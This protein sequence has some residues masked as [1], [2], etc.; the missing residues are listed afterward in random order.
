MAPMSVMERPLN[1]ENRIAAITASVPL[2]ERIGHRPQPPLLDQGRSE[3]I[4]FPIGQQAFQQ[5]LQT[6]AA[7][8]E[9]HEE[10]LV[11]GDN[12]AKL[13]PPSLSAAGAGLGSQGRCGLAA[14]VLPETRFLAKAGLGSR[15]PPHHPACLEI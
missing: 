6:I 8:L 11:A 12:W 14:P 4:A 3:A 2:Q 1:R 9:Q 10:E 15:P 5:R 7:I 13:L